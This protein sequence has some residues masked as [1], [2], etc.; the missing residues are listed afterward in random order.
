M[1]STEKLKYIQGLRALGCISVTIVHFFSIY[2]YE[3]NSYFVAGKSQYILAPFKGDSAVVMFCVLGGFFAYRNL[4]DRE[5]NLTTYIIK[6]YL[7]FMLPAITATMGYYFVAKFL[8]VKGLENDYVHFDSAIPFYKYIVSGLLLNDDFLTAFWILKTLFIG[9]IIIAIVLKFCKE[10]KHRFSVIV[11]LFLILF[12]LDQGYVAVSFFGI[13]LYE[14]VDRNL[15][16]K[17]RK[18]IR[19]ILLILIFIAGYLLFSVSEKISIFPFFYGIAVL[20]IIFVISNVSFLNKIFSSKI[21]NLIGNCS[22]EIYCIHLLVICLVPIFVKSIWI[23]KN[24]VLLVPILILILLIALFFLVLFSYVLHSFFEF[25]MKQYKKCDEKISKIEFSIKK[26]IVKSIKLEIGEEYNPMFFFVGCSIL[27][28][29]VGI[30]VYNGSCGNTG[31]LGTF[32]MDYLAHTGVAERIFRGKL[33]EANQYFQ[34]IYTYPLY[35][36]TTKVLSKLSGL[37][38]QATSG[39]TIMIYLMATILINRYWFSRKNKDVKKQY[40][41]DFLSISSVLVLCIYIPQ[42]VPT[43][44]YPQGGPN[45]WHS[46][47]YLVARPFAILATIFFIKSFMKMKENYTKSLFLFGIILFVG[48]LAK[49]SFAIVILPIAALFVLYAFIVSRGKTIKYSLLCLVVVLPTVLMGYYQLT[50]S[51][52]DSRMGVPLSTAKFDLQTA[53]I[54]LLLMVLFPLFVFLVKGY[55]KIKSPLYIMLWAMVILGWLEYYHT[56]L[57]DFIWGYE[58]VT[59]MLMAYSTYLLFVE[60]DDVSKVAKVIGGSIFAMQLF[61][62]VF[63][64]ATGVLGSNL[65]Y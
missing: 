43:V 60:D 9:P 28:M 65:I 58:M 21:M 59:H 30:Y 53:M 12:A 46:P 26:I 13:V 34:I 10:N 22:Y 52:L 29:L 48:D 27:L 40:V 45:L 56:S 42:I 32:S 16:N 23:D 47:T 24:T 2:I 15:L 64:F 20:G 1:N 55:K 7:R 51:K 54:Y 62:G 5:M 11:I 14:L 18:I 63:Y 19:N 33:N 39:F 44:Y 37:S 25:L 31:Y 17:K 50:Y 8:F 57:G 38:V 36:V 35:H 49:P 6:R 4:K 61:I 41:I 3:A